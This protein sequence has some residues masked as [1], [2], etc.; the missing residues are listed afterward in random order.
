MG[1]G[2]S[3]LPIAR[4]HLFKTVW[5]RQPVG[6]LLFSRVHVNAGIGYQGSH[7]ASIKINAGQIEGQGLA[8]GDRYAT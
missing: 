1:M 5:G 4:T 6:L 3:S 8:V 7:V 2:F